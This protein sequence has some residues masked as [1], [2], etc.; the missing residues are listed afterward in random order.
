MTKVT[1]LFFADCPNWRAVDRQLRE[2]ADELGFELVHHKIAG[3]EEAEREEFAGSPTVLIDDRDPFPS[4]GPSGWT[5]R[6]Y[7][8]DHGPQGAPP[9]D[10]LRAALRRA[11]AGG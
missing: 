11:T 4:D 7:A 5:C 1:L 3:P 6:R 9:A 10:G 8:T 2:L